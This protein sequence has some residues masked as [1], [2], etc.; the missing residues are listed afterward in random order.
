M[1]KDV[2]ILPLRLLSNVTMFYALIIFSLAGKVHMRCKME[3]YEPL[4]REVQPKFYARVWRLTFGKCIAISF[5][6]VKLSIHIIFSKNFQK[7][8]NGWLIHSSKKVFFAHSYRCSLYS[9]LTMCGSEQRM[10]R[11][12]NMKEVLFF[13]KIGYFMVIAPLKVF[14]FNS[15]FCFF[16]GNKTLH[17]YICN[18]IRMR[19]NS[20]RNFTQTWRWVFYYLGTNY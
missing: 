7:F 3:V 2:F 17:W 5:L 8:L 10:N 1:C 16:V 6:Q 18:R 15:I 13:K 9:H 14:T 4:C 11:K 20:S 12:G 19:L